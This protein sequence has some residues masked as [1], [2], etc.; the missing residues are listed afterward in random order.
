VAQDTQ[1]ASAA[2][3]GNSSHACG[4][5]SS[6]QVAVALSLRGRSNPAAEVG[7][8]RKAAHSAWSGTE[9]TLLALGAADLDTSGS[10]VIASSS[11]E[12]SHVLLVR[13]PP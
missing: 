3:R 10:D 9:G 8:G 11:P 2:R 4:F 6:W 7:I 5:A 1:L 12:L 13:A